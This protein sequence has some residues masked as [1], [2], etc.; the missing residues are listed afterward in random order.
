MP[1]DP[2]TTIAPFPNGLPPLDIGIGIDGIA[3]SCD[4][5][6]VYYKVFSSLD[7]YRIPA[8]VLRSGGQDFG[9]QFEHLGRRNHHVGG[10]MYST[11]YMLY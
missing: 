6:Y 8:H 10:M 1:V 2:T 11:K 9:A 5:Q 7:F 4:F 3:M